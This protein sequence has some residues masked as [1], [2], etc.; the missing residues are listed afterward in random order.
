M[1]TDIG[2]QRSTLLD[3]IG[4]T[5]LLE[6]SRLSPKPGVKLFAK[7]EWFNPG[8]SIKD[9][10]A[11]SI[12]NDAEA[13]GALTGNKILLDSTSG[14]TG[15]AYAMI[16]AARRYRVK[17]VVP[18]NINPER[19]RI[20][21]A[22]GAQL[23]LTDPLEGADGA[24]RVAQEIYQKDPGLY[25]FADQYSNDANWRAHFETT[26]PEI[27]E[28]TGG[29]VTHFIAGLG[30]TGTFVGTTRFL[31]KKRPGIQ[32]ITVQPDSPMHG[33]EGMKHLATAIVPR[34]YDS[35]LVDRQVNVSTEKAHQMVLQTARQ[36]GLLIGVSAGAAVAVAQEVLA[37]LNNGLI[38]LVF[39]DSGN[40]YLSES[41]W[42]EYALH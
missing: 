3:L 33:L 29:E 7:A 2:L 20:L 27:W 23:V 13:R 32:A 15:I 12:I 16:G 19:R 30:T 37:D 4:N 24:I 34:I 22:Y 9:R 10:A 17:L 36:E 39:P 5:P 8:G 35:A 18:E 26:G 31:K 28:Q 1:S 41:F 25:F 14:N 42:E 11:L 38:V 21:T 6:L 40:R